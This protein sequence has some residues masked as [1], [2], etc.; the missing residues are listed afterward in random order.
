MAQARPRWHR[1]DVKSRREL[2]RFLAT[3]TCGFI[4]DAGAMLL[5][6]EGLGVTV[7][8]AR[9]VSFPVA[10]TI[11]WL[12]NRHWTFEHGRSRKPSEQY[13]LYLSGQLV[14]LAINF[15]VF[16]ALVLNAQIFAARPVLALA[17]SAVIALGFSYLFARFVSFQQLAR[18]CHASGDR[19][20]E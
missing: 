2:G 14:S 18:V 11:T 16:A 10:V 15:G 9:C 3:G 20:R 17:V 19:P 8:A 6:A 13:V 4:V 7:L 1:T 12:L 5:V